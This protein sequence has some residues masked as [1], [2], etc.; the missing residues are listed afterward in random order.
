MCYKQFYNRDHFHKHLTKYNKECR[1]HYNK[2]A[3]SQKKA[4]SY[5]TTKAKKS[6]IV[7]EPTYGRANQRCNEL[8]SV[9]MSPNEIYDLTHNEVTKLTI[10]Q[11][12]DEKADKRKKKKNSRDKQKQSMKCSD[13]SKDENHNN[14]I[15]DL[16]PDVNKDEYVDE[17]NE[18]DLR[19]L[20]QIVNTNFH[21]REDDDEDMF[22]FG[23]DNSDADDGS[24]NKEDIEDHHENSN[25]ENNDTPKETPNDVLQMNDNT[26]VSH[27]NQTNEEICLIDN[28]L[29]ISSRSTHP[30]QETIN[31]ENDINTR[32]NNDSNTNIFNDNLL[33]HIKSIRNNETPS[34]ASQDSEI[35][36]DGLMLVKYLI[37]KDIPLTCYDDLMKWKHGNQKFKTYISLNQL[38]KTAE[39]KLYGAS[40]SKLI[41]PKQQVLTCPSRRRVTI[42]TSDASAAIVDL[43]SDLHL[44]DLHN[45]NL[46]Q[47]NEDNPFDTHIS[48]YYSDIYQ[49]QVYMSTSKEL[50]NDTTKQHHVGIILAMDEATLDSYSK[51][52]LH[53]VN[54]TLTLY[55]R[56]ARNLSMT[57]RTIGYIPNFEMQLGGKK[58]YT[59]D[60]KL[61][62]FHFCVNHILTNVMYM[63]NRNGMKWKF[64]FSKYPG[65]IYERS[66]IFTLNHIISDAKEHDMLC[67]RMSNRTATKRLC[68]DCDILTEISDNP[69]INCNF[70]KMHNVLQMN[71]DQLKDISFK[72]VTLSPNYAF[73]H[74]NF[75]ANI[76]GINA[77]TPAEPLH[78]ILGGVVER[79]ASTFLLRLNDA[80]NKILDS[81][82]A[83][84]S[85]HFSRQSDRDIYNLKLFKNGVSEVS[86]LTGKEKLARIV[87]IY[88][89]LLS[90]DF[91]SNIIGKQGRKPNDEGAQATV[92]TQKEYNKWLKVF[93]D[94]VI[95]VSWTYLEEHPKAVFNGGRKSVAADALREYMRFYKEAANRKEGMGLKY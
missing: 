89:T 60:Q 55:N 12:D 17:C 51:L 65:R 10:K 79:L 20:Q 59:P 58:K 69:T 2:I 80:Q 14:N 16:N 63:M 28:I 46:L 34:S 41:E 92:I 48:N 37:S 74:M 56:K 32:S 30:H 67:G 39:E 49:S 88:L 26:S 5:G 3:I 91:E 42:I 38:Q 62:D 31:A 66:L 18:E 90:S 36:R 53:P 4:D 45:T 70:H 33:L 24:G 81:H 40:F 11:L 52:S 61:N 94:T 21:N 50:V 22:V 95:F 44:T 15:T 7:L 43:L 47:D 54:M 83:Y 35:Y 6:N 57:W 87:A 93:E 13:D 64:T 86:K 76:Y 75:G 84:L 73:R 85:I 8:S 77:A 78:Q 71:P 29:N 68:R 25:E 1:D 72:D 27:A 19:I 9:N 23:N 82:I